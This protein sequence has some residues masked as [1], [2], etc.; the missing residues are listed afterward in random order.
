MAVVTAAS[1]Y[2]VQFPINAWLTWG[3][4]F[5][6]A[7]FLVNELTNRRHG[8]GSA[9]RVVYIGLCTGLAV[10]LLIA[11]PR[12]ALASAAAFMNAQLCD[13]AIFSRWRQR[14][15][16][17]SAPLISSVSASLLDTT[18]FFAVAFVG[19]DVAWW[20]LGAG[21]FVV[22]VLLDLTMLAPFRAAISLHRSARVT[23]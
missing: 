18:V 6:P 4:F 21:D 5:Y 17:W 19:T 20:R 14:G 7:T 12:I 22:K 16:W 2:L 9:R 1:N 13:I 3:A 8:A 15:A 10:S 23:A 11:T